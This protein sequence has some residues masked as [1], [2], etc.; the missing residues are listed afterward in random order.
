MNEDVLKDALTDTEKDLDIEKLRLKYGCNGERPKLKLKNVI[1][2]FKTITAHRMLV[3]KNCFK[4]GLYFQGLTHD[5]SKYSPVEFFIGCRFYQGNRSPNAKERETYGMSY[6]WLHHKGRNKHH[7]EYWID[8]SSKD[9][10]NPYGIMPAK[11]P[12]KYIAEM[13]ADRVAASRIY[14]GDKYT[15]SS[16]LEYYLTV[17]Q[18]PTPMHPYTRAMLEKFLYMIAEHGE[19]YTFEYIKNVFL[20]KR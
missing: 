13:M 1:G 3:C 5:L 11:M 17:R 4:M 2:H 9:S 14:K 15:N 10:S 16:P 12:D 18:N 7:Y 6:A 19:D 20:K 8:F